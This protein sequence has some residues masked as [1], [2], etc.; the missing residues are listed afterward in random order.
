M[1]FRLPTSLLAPLAVAI[2]LCVLC[3]PAAADSNHGA[4]SPRIDRLQ[5]NHE[6]VSAPLPEC[7]YPRLVTEMP[8]HPPTIVTSGIRETRREFS[9]LE[10]TVSMEPSNRTSTSEQAVLTDLFSTLSLTFE[11]LGYPA[12]ASLVTIESPVAN[13]FVRK[14]KEVVITTAL[15]T[16]VRERSE[17]A[18]ILAHELAHVALQHDSKGSIAAE[19]SADTLALRV[20]TTLSFDPCSGSSVLERLGR[21]S[22]LTLVSLQ[23]RLN[24][25]H[26]KTFKICG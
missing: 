7:R 19:L 12:D 21:P 18:F 6:N 22:E 9:S 14:S 5:S 26:N 15:I 8:S 2:Y 13:A 23:P 3:L 4:P 25:L 17:M 16:R 20:I 10:L 11:R 24:A 1:R